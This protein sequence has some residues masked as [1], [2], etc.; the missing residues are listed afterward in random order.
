[1]NRFCIQQHD[2]RIDW[3]ATLWLWALVG[4]VVFLLITW[5]CS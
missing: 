4:A 3:V 2:G 1:M 5:Y